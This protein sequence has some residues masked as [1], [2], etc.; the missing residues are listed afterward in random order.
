MPLGDK[1]IGDMFSPGSE[2]IRRQTNRVLCNCFEIHALSRRVGL[3]WVF[4]VPLGLA[5]LSN[6]NN[7]NSSESWLKI[8]VTSDNLLP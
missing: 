1:S 5:R 7:H 3:P 4:P 2:R 6:I 8:V